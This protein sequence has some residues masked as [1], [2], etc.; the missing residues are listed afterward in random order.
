MNQE[1]E[2]VSRGTK[3]RRAKRRARTAREA[4]HPRHAELDTPVDWNRIAARYRSMRGRAVKLGYVL[5]G[6]RVA[7][8]CPEEM[9]AN[10]D[11]EMGHLTRG[12]PTN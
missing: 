7:A 11:L 4:L 8:S 1:V 10:T 6:P 9:Q 2:H 12:E 5:I 3:K